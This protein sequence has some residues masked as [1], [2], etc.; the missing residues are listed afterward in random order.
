[1][2][3]EAGLSHK[4]HFADHNFATNFI[5]VSE[6]FTKFSTKLA[7]RV[8][9]GDDRQ[10]ALRT[11][12]GLATGVA[13]FLGFIIDFEVSVNVLNGVGNEGGLP[14]ASPRGLG[15]RHPL[16]MKALGSTSTGLFLA[17]DIDCRGLGLQGDVSP[18]H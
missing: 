7:M 13:H 9:T 11:K 16:S 1:M 3:D 15:H 2:L 14:K 8:A 17:V 10:W 6:T 12:G 18:C 5:I 4:S